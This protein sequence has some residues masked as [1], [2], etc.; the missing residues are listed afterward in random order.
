MRVS[1]I[2]VIVCGKK[3][4]LPLGYVMGGDFGQFF[5]D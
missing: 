4:H 1:D 3:Y 5:G 2:K